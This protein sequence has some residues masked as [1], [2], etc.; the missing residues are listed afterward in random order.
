MNATSGQFVKRACCHQCDQMF[1]V[2]SRPKYA[3][4]SRKV[5]SLGDFFKPLA[6]LSLGKKQADK[7][8][9]HNGVL[10]QLLGLFL[11]VWVI[12]FPFLGVFGHTVRSHCWRLCIGRGGATFSSRVTLRQTLFIHDPIFLLRSDF[13]FDFCCLFLQ[14]ATLTDRVCVSSTFE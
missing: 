9:L 8:L 7:C 13:R 6:S 1:R 14:I 5:P 2:K 12:F 11:E 3:W 10:S 4:V